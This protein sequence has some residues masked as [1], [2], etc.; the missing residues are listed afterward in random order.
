MQFKE[1]FPSNVKKLQ[2]MTDLSIEFAQPCTCFNLSLETNGN[3]YEAIAKRHMATST[4]PSA[5][6]DIPPDFRGGR[7]LWSTDSGAS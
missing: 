3:K 5:L 4:A 1:S 7:V 6:P 2:E